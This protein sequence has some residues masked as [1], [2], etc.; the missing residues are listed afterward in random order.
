MAT[1]SKINKDVKE[2]PEHKAMRGM[3]LAQYLEQ[4]REMLL[5]DLV[6]RLKEVECGISS[7]KEV[8]K[9]HND[10]IKRHMDKL[11]ELRYLKSSLC[12]IRG[13]IINGTLCL[14]E[15]LIDSEI[16]FLPAEVAD[17]SAKGKFRGEEKV[18][19]KKQVNSGSLDGRGLCG[20]PVPLAGSF[21]VEG[22]LETEDGREILFLERESFEKILG[23]DFDGNSWTDDALG[24]YN[25]LA[26][27]WFPKEGREQL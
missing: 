27:N 9:R 1:D 10:H 18:P 15:N 17:D 2:S 24:Y 23:I 4:G 20:E 7:N 5:V 19:P 13:E 12:L 8:I 11:V 21:P 22:T 3:A 25:W 26:R 16:P 14:T 6:A